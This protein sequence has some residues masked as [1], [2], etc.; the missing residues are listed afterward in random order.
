M[1]VNALCLLILTANLLHMMKVLTKT[2]SVYF[3][4]HHLSMPFLQH[5]YT[6]INNSLETKLI[7]YRMV[8]SFQQA[9]SA[10]KIFFIN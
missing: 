9:D 3:H 8:K 2:Q 4:G 6:L 7:K 10:F 1:H 5:Y